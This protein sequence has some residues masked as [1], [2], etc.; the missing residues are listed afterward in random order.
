MKRKLAIATLLAGLAFGAIAAPITV[1][2]V[3]ATGAYEND[4]SAIIDG[5]FPAEGGFFKNNTVWW[6]GT[7]P[8]FTIAFD[9]TYILQDV[10]VSVDNNDWYT[11]QTSMDNSLWSNLFSITK[12]DGEIGNGMDTMSSISGNTEYIAGIDFQA[13]NARYARIYA[14]G[15]DGLYAVGELSFT[16]VAANP[17]PSPPAFI[18][19]LTGLGLLGLTNRFRRAGKET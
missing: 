3:I 4:L 12:W 2:S 16:G 14:T 9:Q 5:V 11:V 17:V 1:T 18:L 7:A 19:M 13:T 15:G 8:V 10:M 6:G